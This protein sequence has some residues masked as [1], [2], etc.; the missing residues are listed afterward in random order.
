MVECRSIDTM[1]MTKVVLF[2]LL[3][4]LALVSAQDSGSGD[5]RINAGAV[6]GKKGSKGSSMGKVRGPCPI[7]H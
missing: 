5:D 3:C 4:G 7:M 1:R 6:S 2:A